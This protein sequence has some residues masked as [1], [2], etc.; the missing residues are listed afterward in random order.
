MRLSFWD[1]FEEEDGGSLRAARHVRVGDIHL[2]E[3]QSVLEVAFP[4]E[5]DPHGIKGH[6]LE[7][8]ERQ[9]VL[10]IQGYYAR[11]PAGGGS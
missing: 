4:N 6:D 2:R 5:F 3:G 9:G 1:V 11:P 7:A 10:H 8:R